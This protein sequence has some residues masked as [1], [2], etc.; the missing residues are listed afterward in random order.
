M[1]GAPLE[2]IRVL[3]FS[4]MLAGPFCTALLADLGADVVKVET[5]EGGD[6]ARHF[7]PRRGGESSYF[8][9]INRGKRSIT[10]NLKA[11]EG[12][13]IAQELARR[14]DIVVENFRPGV[15]ARLGID[16]AALSAI[17]PRLVYASISGFGQEGPLS[18]RPA[19]D[20]IA[21]AMGGIMSVNGSAGAPPTRVGESLGDLC[22]GLYASWAVL[23]ALQGRQRSGEGQYLDV[24]M[25]DSIFSL[26][27]TALS[28]YLYTGKVPAR[29]GNAHPISAPLDSFRAADGHIIIAVANDGVFRGLAR[30]IGRPDLADDPRFASDPERKRNEA[31][32]REVIEAWTSTRSAAEAVA[33]LDAATVPASPILSL[34]Q[35]VASEHAIHRRLVRTVE[36]PT[37]GPIPIVPQ[38]VHFVGAELG[39]PRPSP[40]LGQHTDEILHDLLGHDAAAIAALHRAGIV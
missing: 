21:Q 19:Y 3:D 24:A 29:I 34:D 5:P 36:H 15:A 14:A 37:A 12:L 4:R 7:A 11:P 6:D 38:P 17:N 16:Y 2:G 27:V 26:L 30:V 33:S 22:S 31:A 8:M 28:Q 13:R 23:A 9:L 18:H 32:L 1:T 40:L 20:I 35:V 39:S 25:V 10:L